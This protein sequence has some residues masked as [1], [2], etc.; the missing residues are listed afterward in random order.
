MAS[1]QTY[2][3]SYMGANLVAQQLGWNMTEGWMQG[4]DAANAYYRPIET[5]E[6]RFEAFVDVAV[7]AGFKT[8]DV[9]TGQLNWTWA[10]EAHLAA[11]RRVL[12]ARGVGVASYAGTFGKTPDDF[13]RACRVAVAL[14][15]TILGGMCE[16]LTTDRHATLE[17]L[18]GS[19]RILAI[20]N[21]PEKTPAEVLEKIG[22]DQDVL[23]T[24]VDT[25]WWG[26]QGYSAA[27]AIRE[28]GATV[29]HVHLKDIKAEGAHE[30][31]ALGDG[32]VPIEGCLKEMAAMGYN[33]PVS[34]EHEPDT[35]DPTP[36]VIESKRRVLAWT[37]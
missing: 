22:D 17:I 26:T 36:E 15:T 10:T 25:G 24:A 31:C 21:H 30:S 2:E 29:K 11:A 33:G 4:D 37:S 6:E 32:V 9:W 7:D 34:I 14:E 23:G 3:L 20:E 13:Q 16:A 28:L 35:Y 12:D 8:I 18:R 27:D 5:F 19:G 1:T